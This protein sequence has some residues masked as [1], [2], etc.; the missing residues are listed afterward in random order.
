MRAQLVHAG[1]AQ[2]STPIRTRE[3]PNHVHVQ[4]GAEVAHVASR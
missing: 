1:T 3:P 4:N 2:G